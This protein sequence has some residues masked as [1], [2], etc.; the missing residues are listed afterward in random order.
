MIKQEFKI[1]D[2]VIDI[3]L[4]DGI[5]VIEDI[6]PTW[7]NPILVNFNGINASYN[8]NGTEDN[9]DE[10]PILLH[11]NKN[12]N[13]SIINFNNLPTRENNERWR[14]KYGEKYLAISTKNALIDVDTFEELGESFDQRHYDCGNYFTLDTDLTDQINRMNAIIHEND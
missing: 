13:Y 8:I 11:Y 5:G 6:D 12:Y 3:T 14:A 7:K 2:K 9:L 1:G 10:N 4:I